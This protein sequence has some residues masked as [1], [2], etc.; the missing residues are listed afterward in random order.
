MAPS[1]PSRSERTGQRASPDAGAREEAHASPNE[2]VSAGW[3]RFLGPDHDGVRVDPDTIAVESE[4][5][6]GMPASV[7]PKLAVVPATDASE[8]QAD[9]VA[10]AAAVGPCCAGCAAGTACG[11]TV[12]TKAEPM[13]APRAGPTAS[14]PASSSGEPLSAAVRH[15]VEPVLGADLGHVRVHTD[16]ASREAASDIRA[17]AFTHRNHIYLGPRQSSDDVPLLAHEATHV[18]Q[19]APGDTDGR[20]HRKPEDEQ[21]EFRAQSKK[22]LDEAKEHEGEDAPSDEEAPKSPAEAMHRAPE[23]KKREAE[24]GFKPKLD[25]AVAPTVDRTESSKEAAKDAKDETVKKVEEPPKAPGD[26]GAA[27]AADKG[28]GAKKGALAAISPEAATAKAASLDAFA[29]AASVPLTVD[30]PIGVVPPAPVMPVDA[31]GMPLQPH[32][33]ADAFAGN[34]AER[35]Q[36]MREEGS[37]LRERAA[38]QNLNALRMR[39]NIHVALSGIALAETGITRSQGHQATRRELRGQAGQVL[40]ISEQKAE[41]VATEAPGYVE[42]AAGGREQ[43]QP[44]TEE[45]AGL[46]TENAENT[47]EDEEAAGKSGEQGDKLNKASGDMKTSDSAIAETQKRGEQLV[48]DGAHATETN[49]ATGERLTGLDET[50]TQTDDRLT[51]LSDQA[52]GARAV[53]E[54][55]REVPDQMMATAGMLDLEGLA[56]IDESFAIE[57][58]LHGAQAQFADGMRTVPAAR[59]GGEPVTVQRQPE[60]GYEDRWDIGRAL[61]ETDEDRVQ[62]EKDAHTRRAEELRIIDERSGGDFSRLDGG[63]KVLLALELTGHNL[64]GDI[65]STDWPG[66]AVTLIQGFVD[67][68][69]GL[70]GTFYGFNMAISGF[71]NIFNMEA[72]KKDWL[73]NLLKIAADIVTGI[74]ILLGSIALLATAIALLLTA[75]G[76]AATIFTFGFG[77]GIWAVIGPIIAF[78]SEVAITV[79]PWAVTWAEIAIVLQ[80]L[81]L[82]KN[83][84]Y[85]ACA[86]TADE[87]AQNT[88]KMTVDFEKGA[89][90]AAIILPARVLGTGGQGPDPPAP[91]LRPPPPPGVVPEPVPSGFGLRPAFAGG[92][93]PMGGV[94][95]PSVWGPRGAPEPVM[96]KGP[97]PEV[98]VEVPGITPEPVPVEPTPVKPVPVTPTPVEPVPAEPVPVKPT[99]AEPAPVKP[100]PA[101]PTPAEPAPAQPAPA[102]PAPAEPTKPLIPGFPEVPPLPDVWPHPIPVTPPPKLTPE[103]EPNPEDALDPE[104]DPEPDVGPGPGE[105]EP[106]PEPEEPVCPP[107]TLPINWPSPAPWAVHGIGD[108]GANTPAYNKPTQQLITR[109][110]P[111]PARKRSIRDAY[112]NNPINQAA[113]KIA[114]KA[115]KKGQIHHK[116][117]LF[118]DGPDTI[119]NLVFLETKPVNRHSA[120]HVELYRQPHGYILW[121][122]N[123]TQYCVL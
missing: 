113:L 114:A 30:P 6:M 54:G 92:P 31:A 4:A 64:W 118:V 71:A 84:I 49:T 68:R 25:P 34:L 8:R 95:R 9:R 33:Q 24:T 26:K 109:R 2:G 70:A 110:K 29:A 101:K 65:R 22:E 81:V 102:K 1:V 7:Q 111:P 67:P 88:E 36:Y 93:E 75:I 85:A 94:G 28:A 66:F 78:C 112:I 117:P 120:W 98:P 79:G 57:A 50:L 40:G 37:R 42:R 62:R 115:K 48:A 32:P 103:P 91:G 86:T 19:Q 13:A 3:P 61:T 35:I 106:E 44:V 53:M 55:L 107:G 16:L 56:L 52:G 63:D 87:L 89:Q 123:G 12:Q 45:A 72:W 108:M 60:Y 27:G 11:K 38:V 59:G 18:M 96:F 82:I 116:W 100:A 47:P 69:I 83:L 73:G 14:L 5:E 105:P 74:A 90:M 20:I 99:P 119:A 104:T 77:S 80:E 41:L 43:S 97:A 58:A 15:R 17:K 122:K 10:E 39:G 51:E 46:V 76:V 23:G 121:D 21:A